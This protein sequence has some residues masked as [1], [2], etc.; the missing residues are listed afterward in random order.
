MFDAANGT[1]YV[2][3]M[4]YP[5]GT[6]D[7]MHFSYDFTTGDKVDDAA[8]KRNAYITL[9]IRGAVGVAYFDD[10]RLEEVEPARAGP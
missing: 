10:V 9:R 5:N 1:H 6:T 4:Y 8:A 7:W 2:P 3:D